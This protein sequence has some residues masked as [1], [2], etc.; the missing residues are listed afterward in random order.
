MMGTIFMIACKAIMS[1]KQ[2]LD[3]FIS[4]YSP[5]VAGVARKAFAWM[6]KKFP[7]ASVMVY[8]NYN[9]LAIGFGPTE[10][11]SDAVFS[12]ALFPHWVN[13]FFLQ[14]AGVPD[15]NKLLKS[16]ESECAAFGWR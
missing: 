13:L 14:G 5:E 16:P 7:S 2:Q 8:D 1:G 11:A 3:S 12:I 4:N 9:A 15:P 6:R 10:R